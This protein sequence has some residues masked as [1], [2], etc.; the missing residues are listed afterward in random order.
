MDDLLLLPVYL[1]NPPIS[2]FRENKNILLD[3]ILMVCKKKW[4]DDSYRTHAIYFLDGVCNKKEE[5][6]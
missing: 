5:V 4:T 3:E 2:I 6:L 1:L